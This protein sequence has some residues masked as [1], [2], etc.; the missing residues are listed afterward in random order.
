MKYIHNDTIR[1]K[2]TVLFRVIISLLLL[3]AGGLL[4]FLLLQ[5]D[6]VNAGKRAIYL[7]C[8]LNKLTGLYCPGCG[9]TRAGFDILH[10]DIISAIHNNALIVFVFGPFA[11]YMALREYLFFIM[12]KQVLPF[13][14]L[15]TWMIILIVIIT[16][17]FTILRNLPFAPFNWIAPTGY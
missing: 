9:M 6:P 5:Y 11:A 10:F 4:I 15:K 16:V 13:P 12:Q 7:F 3:L 2:D 14:K 1:E 17:A 8:P